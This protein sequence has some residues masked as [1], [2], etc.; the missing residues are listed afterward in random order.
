MASLA[1]SASLEI[2]WIS[3]QQAS[4]THVVLCAIPQMKELLVNGNPT[5]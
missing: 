3:T 2:A 5:C 4:I 1:H